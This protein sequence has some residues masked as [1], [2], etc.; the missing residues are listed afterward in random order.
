MR[1]HVDNPYKCKKCTK[2]FADSY[3]LKCHEALHL[4]P[5]HCKYCNKQFPKSSR[6]V[7]K[8]HEMVHTGEKPFQCRICSKRFSLK[9]YL[10]RHERIHRGERPFKCKFCDKAFIESRKLRR[11]LQSNIHKKDNH[12][13]CNS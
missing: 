4:E 9:G 12:I 1:K 10:K 6:S 11:H 3:S 8:N 7:L 5:L 13:Q 2:H